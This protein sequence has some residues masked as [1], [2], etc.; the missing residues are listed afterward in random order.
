MQSFQDFW[1][2]LSSLSTWLS[3]PQI[4]SKISAKCFSWIWNSARRIPM[5]WS[6]NWSNIYVEKWYLMNSSFHWL[7]PQVL[8]WHKSYHHIRLYFC[9]VCLPCQTQMFNSR[10]LWCH[11]L[12][13]WCMSSKMEQSYSSFLSSNSSPRRWYYIGSSKCS[14][15]GY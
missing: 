7:L 14:S 5:S 6:T 10:F 8:L 9:H 4:C 15:H 2:L 1:L 11:N 13:L 3:S 12:I